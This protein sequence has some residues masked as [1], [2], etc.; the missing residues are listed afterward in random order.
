[1]NAGAKLLAFAAGLVI[2][3]VVGLGLGATLGPA[4]R[5]P[6]VHGGHPS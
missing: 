5:P 2:V 3:F 1:M 6:A 4:P